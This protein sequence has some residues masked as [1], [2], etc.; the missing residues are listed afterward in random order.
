MVLQV[1]GDSFV[2]DDNRIVGERKS[3]SCAN[4]RR[5]DIQFWTH[6]FENSCE[7]FRKQRLAKTQD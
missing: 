3:S 1:G 6:N 4:L 2:I 5:S 7:T